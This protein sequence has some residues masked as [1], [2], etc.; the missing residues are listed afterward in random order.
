MRETLERLIRLQRADDGIVDL[1]TR[2]GELDQQLDGA[3]RALD[4]ARNAVAEAHQIRQEAQAATHRKEID[5]AE[6]EGEI[7][8]LEAQLNTASSNKEF[9][10]IQLKIGHIQAENGKREESIILSMDDVDEKERREEAAKA[11][12]REAEAALRAAEEKVEQQRKGLIETLAAA[13]SEREELAASI[14]AQK[15]TLYERIRG[16][17]RKSGTAVVAVHGE[18]CQG[19][20][21]AVRP[22]DLSDL[23]G[24]QTL[25]LCSSCQRILVLEA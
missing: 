12:Q 8:K 1:E 18:Y 14:D 2:I 3:R 13:Q 9:Q 20:Q 16:G 24:G 6:A 7:R 15:L 5:L 4:A 19:C 25:V 11:A 17:N 22:Q 10:A 23:I 21:M